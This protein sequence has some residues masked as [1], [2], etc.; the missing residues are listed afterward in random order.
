MNNFPI[1]LPIIVVAAVVVLVAAVLIISW[2]MEK[3][4]TEAFARLADSLN[5]EFLPKGDVALLND[6]RTFHLFGLGHSRLMKNLLRGS[7]QGLEIGI[8]DYR[9]I[10][11]YGKH[12]QT[13]QQSVF[14]ASAR[15]MNLAKFSM[16]PE[17]F[18]HKVSSLLG[19]KDIVF[20]SHPGFSKK[21]LL[22]GPDETATRELFTP[23][24][25]DYFEE[26]RGRNVEGE[27]DL[28]IYYRYSRLKPEQIR[29][30]MGEGFEVL[31]IF[32]TPAE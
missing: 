1:P 14:V 12:Q 6:L 13:F 20:D 21:Y 29:D 27:G 9:Y 5:F 31:N 30:F 11:G 26:T 22:K 15:D 4:R 28:L 8:F 24:V 10:V 3:K 23:E 7:A 2:Y 18:W 25:L 17:S 16:R 19:F 32:R